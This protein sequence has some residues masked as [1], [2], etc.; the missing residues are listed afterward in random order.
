MFSPTRSGL[1]MNWWS[2]ASAL[3]VLLFA[4]S[5][6]SAQ[7]L[8]PPRE[9]IEFVEPIVSDETMPAEVGD[10]ILRVSAEH[11]RERG[12]APR[13][14]LF[15]GVA[16]RVGVELD[17]PFAYDTSGTADYGLDT[18]SASLKWLVRVPGRRSP[19]LVVGVETTLAAARD[20]ATS[21]VAPFVSVLQ[22]FDRFTVQGNVG[23]ALP[24]GNARHDRDAELFY[25][26]A[27]ALPF[28]DARV[29]VLGEVGG[30]AGNDTELTLSPGIKYR[31][32]EDTFVAV[33]VPFETTGEKDRRVVVQF[34]FALTR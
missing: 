12:A 6:A 29:H 1:P 32:R 33:A 31:L 7:E 22:D 28:A 8:P 21:E 19:A 2:T 18:I 4:S 27:I 23:P 25:N 17:A 3:L 34:Q 10:W 20:D 30:V 9:P 14:Q 16:S 11:G 15:F 13:L 5:S 24:A 26:V